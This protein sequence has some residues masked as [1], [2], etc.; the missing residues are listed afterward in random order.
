MYMYMFT[1]NYIVMYMYCSFNNNEV[2]HVLFLSIHV[3]FLQAMNDSWM[4]ANESN[5]IAGASPYPTDEKMQGGMCV[6]LDSY[7]TDISP[8][9]DTELVSVLVLV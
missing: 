1:Y 2:V 6:E 9:L 3:M 7:R 8:C 4:K 5:Y